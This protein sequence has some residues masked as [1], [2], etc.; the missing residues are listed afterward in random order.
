MVKLKLEWDFLQFKSFPSSMKA[1][2][3]YGYA[4]YTHPSGHHDIAGFP[5]EIPIKPMSRIMVKCSMKTLNVAPPGTP[6][7]PPGYWTEARVHI[8]FLRGEEIIKRWYPCEL[9]GDTG[10]VVLSKEENAPIESNAIRIL[11]FAGGK[12]GETSFTWFDDLKIYMDDKL[13]YANNFSNWNPYI[14]AG[15]GAAIGAIAG[16]FIKPLG[17][18]VSEAT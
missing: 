18:V 4:V 8:Q 15:A 9:W 10:W 6:V 1:T 3:S 14:G 2:N 12:P 7:R 17:P 16:Y 11:L 5:V 13:I